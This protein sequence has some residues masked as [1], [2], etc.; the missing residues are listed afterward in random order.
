MRA[1]A[2]HPVAV[3]NPIPLPQAWRVRA[4]EL[5]PSGPPYV[6][7]SPGAGIKQTGK[8]WPL[9]A[10]VASAVKEVQNKK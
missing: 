10:F 3:T 9:D 2:G 7:L 8:C 4:A 1:A 6:G 5:L